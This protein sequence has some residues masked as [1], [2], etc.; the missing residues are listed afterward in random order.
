[1]DPDPAPYPDPTTDPTPFFS[2]FKDAKK[3]FFLHMRKGKDPDSGPYLWEAQKHVD[4]ADPDPQ[5]C[6]REHWPGDDTVVVAVHL[7]EGGLGQALV[8]HLS[9]RVRQGMK[10]LHQ[11]LEYDTI[12][13]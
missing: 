11:S 12:A 3:I 13:I 5:H 7:A 2:D 8:S 9:L 10:I 1:M 6:Y 4:P